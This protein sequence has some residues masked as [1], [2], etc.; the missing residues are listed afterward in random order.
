MDENIN[1]NGEVLVRLL[2]F[3]HSTG[4][5]TVQTE[6]GAVIV[7]AFGD[8]SYFRAGNVGYLRNGDDMS[9]REAIDK[10]VAEQFG[11]RPPLPRIVESNE[12]GG[13]WFVWNNDPKADVPLTM[14]AL[15]ALRQV[16]D[17]PV[18][19]AS[20]SQVKSEWKQIFPLNDEM[21]DGER[22]ERT[23][24]AG[25]QWAINRTKEETAFTIWRLTVT[26]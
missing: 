7:S 15:S 22:W 18:V 26:R 12:Y 3:E 16:A 11:Q 9:V 4:H 25:A 19:D 14:G 8:I 21:M 6:V 1:N 2:V 20:E 10:A 23:W 5:V 17:L 13:G 24:T